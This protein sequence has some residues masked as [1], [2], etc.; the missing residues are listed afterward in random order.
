[1]D[2][3]IYSEAWFKLFGFV[4]AKRENSENVSNQPLH[5]SGYARALDEVIEYMMKLGRCE[6]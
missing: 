3:M 4:D 1:M 6:A 2:R 5:N